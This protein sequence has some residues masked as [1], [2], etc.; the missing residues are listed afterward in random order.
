MDCD[1][2]VVWWLNGPRQYRRSL[3]ALCALA[4]SQRTIPALVEADSDC[5]CHDASILPGL[6]T[7]TLGFVL[8]DLMEQLLTKWYLCCTGFCETII[9]NG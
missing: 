1:A 9:N 2:W 6:F 4:P 7:P 3:P 5:E 8:Q